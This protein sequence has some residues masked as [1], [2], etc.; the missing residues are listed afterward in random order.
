MPTS[1]SSRTVHKNPQLGSTLGNNAGGS[2]VSR[3]LSG[4]SCFSTPSLT[5]PITPSTSCE[6]PIPFSLIDKEP[7]IL[8]EKDTFK[9]CW[10]CFGDESDSEGV[11]VKPCHC[12]LVSHEE[13]L[14]AWISENQKGQSQKKVQCP[15]C[16]ETYRLSEPPS[17]LVDL[18]VKVDGLIQATVPY[19]TLVG[20]TGSVLVT[21]T[22]YGAYAVLTVCGAEEG[23]KLLGSPQP[24]GWRVWLGLPMIPWALISSRTTYLDSFMPLLPILVLGN[25]QIKLEMPPSPKLIISVL[26]WVRLF[27]NSAWHYLFN[28]LERGWRD[29]SRGLLGYFNV[30]Q[31]DS[32]PLLELQDN[33]DEWELDPPQATQNQEA[34]AD[35]AAYILSERKDLA[36][37][38]VGALLLP[39]ISSFA[40][41]FLG[42][43]PFIR[44]RL[45]DAFI[46]SV[47]GGCMFIFLKDITS[48]LYKYHLVRRLRRRHVKSIEPRR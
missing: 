32:E 2:P 4:T 35:P 29:Q 39:A 10:I 37:T 7:T 6:S 42:T 41:N 47:I 31:E 11:W 33:N 16:N 44:N 1:F 5:S 23:E 3:S 27:Y 22:T 46:R 48:L 17:F 45:P 26:P 34:A 43:I 40:G 8:F 36:R 21:S 30:S 18:F 14:L 38:I 25:D 28:H 13:C 12:S 15:Q 19:I 24:W 9:R 20:L